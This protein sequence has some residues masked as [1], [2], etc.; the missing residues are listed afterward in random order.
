MPP[1]NISIKPIDFNIA[2]LEIDLAGK[3][4][5]VTYECI[6]SYDWGVDDDGTQGQV[7]G[8]DNHEQ[9]TSGWVLTGISCGYI[10]CGGG[11]E[12]GG[13]YTPT[14]NNSGGGTGDS[15][16]GN[17]QDPSDP[18][19]HGNGG[20]I[21]TPIE[22]NNNLY[23]TGDNCDD[24][25]NFSTSAYSSTAFTNLENNINSTEEKGYLIKAINDFPYFE[26]YPINSSENCTEIHI[27]PNPLVF[28]IMHTHPNN[29]NGQGTYPMFYIGDLHTLYQLTQTY[30]PNIAPNLPSGTSIYT[31]YMTVNNYTYALKINNLTKLN[32]I[33]DI[34]SDD[35]ELEDFINKFEKAY[36]PGPSDPVNLSQGQLAETLLGIMEEYDLGISLYRST[37]DDIKHDPRP[38]M[39]QTSNWK[40]LKLDNSNNLNDDETCS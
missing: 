27:P 33:G 15:G 9:W 19:V 4:T 24:L 38:N 18:D 32:K 39:P 29:C 16:D 35:E 7:V 23:I 8:A 37:H 20:F 25:H 6:E 5:G 10:S 34:F 28:A 30:N 3:C 21:S 36:S 11:A 14:G 17:D 1:L 22:T 13:F 2:D 26:P 12:E 31:V 40:R